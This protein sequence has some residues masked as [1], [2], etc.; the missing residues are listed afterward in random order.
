MMERRKCSLSVMTSK[1]RENWELISVL[2]TQ[3]DCMDIIKKF[4]KKILDDEMASLCTNRKPS[5]FKVN[6][7][8]RL[9]DCIDYNKQ[10]RELKERAPLFY[11][12]V[13]HKPQFGET[14]HPTQRELYHTSCH[15]R[16]KCLVNV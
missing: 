15:K 2:L 13:M 6:N 10:I 8:C 1:S 16:S 14:K 9:V 4:I 5:S 3:Y 7:I 12:V 11:C